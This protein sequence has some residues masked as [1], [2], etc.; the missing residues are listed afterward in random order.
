MILFFFCWGLAFF[1]LGELENDENNKI[2]YYEKAIEKHEKT[3]KSDK[4][5]NLY[6]GITYFKLYSLYKKKVT[7]HFEYSNRSILDILYL[8]NSLIDENINETDIFIPLLA[9]KLKDNNVDSKFFNEIIK[10]N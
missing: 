9:Y 3:I 5:I 8:Y 6:I 7:K 10:G 1:K 4:D 2:S